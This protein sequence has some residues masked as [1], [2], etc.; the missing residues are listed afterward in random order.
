MICKARCDFVRAG[1][2]VSKRCFYVGGVTR[3]WAA[4][5]ETE[6]AISEQDIRYVRRAA[7]LA[8]NHANEGNRHA[9]EGA[10][11]SVGRV[12]GHDDAYAHELRD[13]V[14]SLLRAVAA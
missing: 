6:M 14:A 4:D 5:G 1:L 9:A 12:L 10:A 3:R 11:W 7:E 8:I 2:D 13:L